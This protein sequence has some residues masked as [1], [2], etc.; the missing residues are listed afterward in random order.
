[1]D[2][3]PISPSRLQMSQ[4]VNSS[5]LQS[6]RRM[7][8][9]ALRTSHSSRSPSAN[10]SMEFHAHCVNSADSCTLRLRPARLKGV[11]LHLPEVTS[12]TSEHR[13]RGYPDVVAI[14]RSNEEL[15]T[16]QAQ[17]SADVAGVLQHRSS[18][19]VFCNSRAAHTTSAALDMD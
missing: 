17:G 13:G 14:P 6:L 11:C 1:M 18:A 10:P 15:L 3:F 16:W 12:C 9:G 5:S 19:R 4:L 7:G 2:S 8:G